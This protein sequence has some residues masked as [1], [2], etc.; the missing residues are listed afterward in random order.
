MNNGVK[1]TC[2]H[3]IAM[4]NK[5]VL[6]TNCLI[7]A[8]SRHSEYYPVWQ[9]ILSGKYVLCVSNDIISEY[10]EIIAIKTAKRLGYQTV[11]C[12]YLRD[13]P[14]QYHVDRFY[15]ESTTDK[16]AVLKVAK[17]EGIDGVLAYAS[18]PAAPTAAYVAE[19]LGL[20]GN[21]YESVRILCEKDLF[22]Q[23]LRKHGF[24]TPAARGYSS[25]K[26]AETDIITGRF[27]LPVVVKPVD[28]SGS[29]G[30]FRIDAGCV[31]KT[32]YFLNKSMSY[33]RAKRVIVEEWVEK[34]GY[35]IA[36]DGMSID[37]KLVFRC[38]GSDHFNPLCENPYVPVS[39]S[40]PSGLPEN[41]QEK[42]HGTIQRR[43]ATGINL[44]EYCVRSAMGEKI[45]SPDLIEPEGFWSYYAVHSL[46]SGILVSI[47]IKD[48]FKDK[49]IE[50]HLIKH[51]GDHVF[52]FTEANTSLG[53]LI[54][55][56]SSMHEMHSMM[57][58]SEQ[59]ITVHV[60]K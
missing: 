49:V 27:K 28:S 46:Q 8:L 58:H 48:P 45:S 9:G 31:E 54:M 14:G 2:A 20:P 7:M 26:D 23:F 19:K 43:Y 5:V 13:N 22:R 37:G 44:T 39:A 21:P 56:F 60:K 50:N 24:C 32:R 4:L 42:V 3:H 12:D 10:Q 36:G 53:C 52:S 34:H 17:A 15:L 59:W 33:S 38:F 25:I 29:K 18:D 6:D 35:Q 41:V 55:K 1:N 11:L 16:D 51:S 57:D 40:F 47:E 30:V